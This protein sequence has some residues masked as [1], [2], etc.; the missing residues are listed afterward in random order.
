MNKI[1]ISQAHLTCIENRKKQKKINRKYN[2][3]VGEM[4][5]A[6]AQC[7]KPLKVGDVA[8]KTARL[9]Y[10]QD[11]GEKAEINV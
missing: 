4:A 7:N 3:K 10:C 8:Y 1:I 6:N 2:R 11:C 5:C 9:L